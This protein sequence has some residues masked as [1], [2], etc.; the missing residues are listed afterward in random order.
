MKRDN[1]HLNG[2]VYYLFFFFYSFLLRLC[3]YVMPV[4]DNKKKVT[5][6]VGTLVFKTREDHTKK[7]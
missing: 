1:I 7:K 2:G 3:I 5:E 6:V 4:Y